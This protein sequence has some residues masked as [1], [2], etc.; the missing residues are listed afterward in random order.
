MSPKKLLL[1]FLLFF[2]CAGCASLQDAI[3][4][5]MHTDRG[6][7]SAILPFLLERYQLKMERR[8]P[9]RQSPMPSVTPSVDQG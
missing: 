4:R 6:Y 2:P 7:R 1:I 9:L 8:E 5:T 3:V